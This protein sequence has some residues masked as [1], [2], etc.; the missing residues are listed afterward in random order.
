M[1]T[2]GP[3]VPVSTPLINDI[4]NH[5]TDVVLLIESEGEIS[6][7]SPS[8]R[9]I[10]GRSG[11]DE[12]ADFYADVHPEDRQRV[13]LELASIFQSGIMRDIA[14]RLQLSDGTV[15]YI[16]ATV[17]KTEGDEKMRDLLLLVGQDVTHS[18]EA[19]TKER[20]LAHAVSCTRDC[21]CLTDLDDKILFVNPSFC[22]VYGYAEEELIGEKI[23]IVRSPRVPD[24]GYKEVIARTTAGEW[25]GEI[26]NCRKDGTEFP[27]ELW[28]TVVRDQRGAPVAHAGIVRDISDRK[29]IEDERQANLAMFQSLVENLMAGVLVQ[30]ENGTVFLVNQEFCRI[31]SIDRTMIGSEMDEPSMYNILAQSV[32]DPKAF[33]ASALVLRQERDLSLGEEIV[34]TNDRIIERD[35][36]PIISKGNRFTGHLWQYRDVTER[37]RSSALLSQSEEKFRTLFEE[38]LDGIIIST[39]GGIVLDVNQAALKILG[40]AVKEELLHSDIAR[41]IYFNPDDRIVFKETLERNG[42]VRDFEFLVKRKDGSKRVLSESATAARDTNGE[43]VSYRGYIRDITDHRVLEEELLQ[44]QKMEGIGTL[45][46]GIAHDFNN[47]LGI[48]LGYATLLESGTQTPENYTRSIDRI[49]NAVDRGASLVRQLLAFAQKADPTLESISV[50]AVVNELA[51]IVRQTFPRT[52]TIETLLDSSLPSILADSGQIHQVLMN[53][54]LNARDAMSEERGGNGGG[55][56]TISTG[57]TKGEALRHRFPAATADEYVSIMVTDTGVGLDE[58]TRQHI[59]EPFFTTKGFGKGSGLGLA[60]VYGVVNNHHGFTDVLSEPHESTSFMLYF[61]TAQAVHRQTRIPLAPSIKPQ[62][63]QELLLLVED[64]ALLLELL[65]NFLEDHG[66]RIIGA[67]DGLEALNLFKEHHRDIAVILSDMGLPGLGGWELFQKMK[68]I[69]PDVQVILASGYFDP[70]L[71]LDLVNAGARDFIKKPYIVE[72]ILQKLRQIIREAKEAVPGE[73]PGSAG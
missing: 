36:I 55:S 16:E 66:Y 1:T 17:R 8:Y 43:I 47:I 39:P 18:W 41:D 4:L 60:V 2:S 50:N 34:L 58:T 49:K 29:R 42:Y 9:H 6:F 24:P 7:A 28:V 72:E 45:A 56:L 14:L 48:I 19:E 65:K 73:V 3:T 38:S 31:F 57:R 51:S 35:Y 44:A 71:K 62:G 5:I 22:Q 52:I 59:F 13:R 67:H 68:E 54:C 69:K 61:P 26:V 70:K 32:E 53:L 11:T 25:F 64:E 63:E 12:R 23:S 37:R 30:N 21:F 10:T 33:F 20:L 40:Y 46:G 15:R 27:I